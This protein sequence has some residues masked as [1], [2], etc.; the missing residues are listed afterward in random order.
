MIPEYG[1]GTV[2]VGIGNPEQVP[3]PC[4]APLHGNVGNPGIERTA[5]AGQFF[6]NYIADLVGELAQGLAGDLVAKPTQLLGFEDI[7]HAGIRPGTDHRPT[8]ARVPPPALRP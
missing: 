4:R 1:D 7:E 5:L 6:I 2:S 8:A 3:R